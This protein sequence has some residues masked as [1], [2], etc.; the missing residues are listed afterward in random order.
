MTGRRRD[1]S[2]SALWDSLALFDAHLGGW[3]RASRQQR[4]HN[5]P[6]ANV[7][8]PAGRPAPQAGKDFNMPPI[9]SAGIEEHL[10]PGNP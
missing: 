5:V 2:V 4:D 3:S 1:A 6:T 7:S 10:G 8:L 9:T